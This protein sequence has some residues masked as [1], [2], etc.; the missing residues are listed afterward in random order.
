[1]APRRSRILDTDQAGIAVRPGP[2]A[3]PHL[4]RTGHEAVVTEF[5]QALI[6]AGEAFVRFAG[7]LLG[8]EAREHNLSGQDCIILQQL[9][10]AG[11]PSRIA[12]LLRF[13]NREDVSNVQYSLRKL[14]KAG[15]VR[16]VKGATNRDMAYAVTEDGARATSR[17]VSLRQELLMLP[18]KE[19]A[20][21]DSQ[22]RSMTAALGLLTGLYDHGSRVLVGR[23]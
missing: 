23:R 21:L 7:A 1:M 17:L 18:T 20:G 11:Q 10:T 16:Q 3:P 12:D 22:L 9:V 4:A 6:C 14:I 13:A 19:I 8:P 5:E 15:L 2:P